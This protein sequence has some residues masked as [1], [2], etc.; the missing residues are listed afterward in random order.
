[1]STDPSKYVFNHT[2]IRVKDA[3]ASVQFYTNVLGMK[4]ITKKDFESSKFS[5]YFLAYVDKVPEDEEEKSVMAFSLPGVLELT[6]NWGTENDADFSYANGNKEPGRG[7]GHIAIL[8]DDIEKACERFESLNVKFVKKLK[9]GNMKNIAFIA[10]PDGYWI[11]V[12]LFLWPKR[13]RDNG[14]S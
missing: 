6:H 9:D 5:L 7:F 2:M 13:K 3:D 11:E 1:M 12:K 8:V 14:Y 4:L 10:D